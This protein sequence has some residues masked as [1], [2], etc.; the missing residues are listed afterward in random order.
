MRQNFKPTLPSGF[1][2]YLPEDEKTRNRMLDVVKKNFELFGFLPLD[3]PAVEEERTLTGGD[4]EFKKQI[5]RIKKEGQKEELALRFDLTVPLARVISLYPNQIS[6]P[7]KRY[8]VGKVWRGEKPQAGR[9]REFLQFDADIVGSSKLSADAEIISLINQVMVSLGFDNFLI[10]INN[11]KILDF[12]PEY[13]GFSKD[14]LD[15]V[16]RTLDK[17]DKIGEREVLKELSS[18]KG[19]GLSS[20]ESKALLGFLNIEAKNNPELIKKAEEKLGKKASEEFFKMEK[21]A[22]LLKSLGLQDEKWVFD[23]STV[24]G[25]SYYTGFVFETVLLDMPEVGS[26]FSGGRYDGLISK[27]GGSNI[28]AVGVSLGVDRIMYAMKKLGIAAGFKN[29][30]KILVLD[31]DDQAFPNPEKAVSL[32]RRNGLPAEIYLGQ[33][34]TLKGQMAYAL[35]NDYDLAIIIGEREAGK[36]SVTIKNFKTYKQTEIDFSGLVSEVRKY[37]DE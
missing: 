20:L 17:L 23:F 16:L 12:L 21:L 19:A 33:E 14:K 5:F 15:P 30:K 9:Y 3:T 10:K 6:F 24:R 36:G 27:M 37:I 32:L 28:P 34:K 26:V 13:A 35:K 29:D 8:Q 7:F 31:F 18:K 25:L 1:K 22:E 4:P 11:R 2:D